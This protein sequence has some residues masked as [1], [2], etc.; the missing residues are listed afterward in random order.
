[1]TPSMIEWT[2]EFLE[3]VRAELSSH[4]P[5]V[6]LRG[7]APSVS[8]EPYGIRFR[9]DGSQYWLV[10]TPELLGTE[11]L[12]VQQVASHL[13]ERDWISTMKGAGGITVDVVGMDRPE[14]VLIPWTTGDPERKG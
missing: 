14:P 9:E 5:G 7:S 8:P 11:G 3:W 4:W 6:R 2:L 10:L 12:G 1:M 13:T